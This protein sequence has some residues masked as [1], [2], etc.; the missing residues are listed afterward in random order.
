[1]ADA[2]DDTLTIALRRP[3][4]ANGNDYTEVVL[5]EPTLGNLIEASKAKTDMEQTQRMISL[6]AEIPMPAVAQL[7]ITV[8]TEAT[9]FFARFLPKSPPTGET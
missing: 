5:R 6:C 7:P 3:V 8:V 1:M 2:Y 4:T 9:E